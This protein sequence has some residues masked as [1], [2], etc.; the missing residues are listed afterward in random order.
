VLSVHA[1]NSEW[2]DRAKK[3]LEATGAEDIASSSE[4]KGD[5]ANSKRPAVK[6]GD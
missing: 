6:Y 1:D 5:Y 4:A 3:I 2:I